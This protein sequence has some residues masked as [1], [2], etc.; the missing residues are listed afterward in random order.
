MREGGL[1][2]K[3]E[4]HD[5]DQQD[6]QFWAVR[7]S[8]HYGRCTSLSDRRASSLGVKFKTK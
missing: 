6:S 3:K 8:S 5:L 4:E 1:D 2:E 7:V